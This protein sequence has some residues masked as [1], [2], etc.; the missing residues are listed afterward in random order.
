MSKITKNS[1]HLFLSMVLG[2]GHLDKYGQL[3]LLHSDK[4]LEYLE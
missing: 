3:N 1:R 2:D 4:Q